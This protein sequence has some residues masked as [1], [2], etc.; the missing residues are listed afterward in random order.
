MDLVVYTDG[1]SFN[2]PGP[3][4]SAFAIYYQNKLVFSHQ[5]AIGTNTNNVAE[6]TALI[7]ALKK[8]ENLLSNQYREA[9]GVHIYSDSQLMVRQ[10]TGLYKI[11]NAQIGRLAFEAKSLERALRVPVSYTS[12][13]REQNSFVDSLVKKALGR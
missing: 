2:N 13:P 12:I 9:R 11:K 8:V 4:A 10:M 1:G 3:A 6:Y 7:L 5:Q